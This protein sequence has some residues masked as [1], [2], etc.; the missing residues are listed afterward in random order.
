MI[1]KQSNGGTI[2]VAGS[3]LHAS[4][5]NMWLIGNQEQRTWVMGGYSDAPTKLVLDAPRQSLHVNN[6]RFGTIAITGDDVKM[7]CNQE[8]SLGTR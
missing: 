3:K 8:A 5:A 6:F 2:E 4:G 7:D 1:A